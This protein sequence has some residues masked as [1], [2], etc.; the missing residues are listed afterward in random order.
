M[1]EFW[2]S[3]REES[4]EKRVHKK[5]IA[6]VMAAATNSHGINHTVVY[7]FF[8]FRDLFQGSLYEC[9]LNV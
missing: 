2:R 5:K 8:F 7:K 9:I 3:R 1:L 4:I 6:A